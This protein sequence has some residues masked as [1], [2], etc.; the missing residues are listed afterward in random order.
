MTSRTVGSTAENRRIDSWKEIAA[1]FGRDERTVKRW[2]KE[3]GLP[4]HRLPG[5]RGGVFAWSSELTAW[6]N[7]SAAAVNSKSDERPLAAETPPAPLTPAVPPP[8]VPSPD[9]SASESAPAAPSPSVTATILWALALVA[10]VFAVSFFGLRFI[11][12]S[13]RAPR[14]A[15]RGTAPHHV[16]DPEAREFYLKG[17]YYWSRRTEGSLR[18]AVDA[19]T[20]AVIHDSEYA[21]A[22]AGL[23]ECYDIMPEFSSMPRSEAFP[24]AIAAAR[25][26]EALD[27][28]LAEAHRALAFALFYWEWKVP[29]AL[30]EYQRAL[31]LD[32]R[33]E[34][35]HH[36][37]ATSLLTLGRYQEAMVEIDKA[38]QLNPASRS[39]LSDQ[40]L[41]R[42]WNGDQPAAI[43]KLR[44]IEQAEPEFF[45]AP[46]YLAGIAFAQ[47]D[48][49][50]FIDQSKRLAGM[51]G[52][53]QLLAVTK[54]AQRGFTTG[55]EHGLLEAIRE[56]QQGYFDSGQASGLELARTCALLGRKQ[57]AVTYLKAAIA[58]HDYMVLNISA[59]PTFALL[60]GDP[61]F[62]QVLRQITARMYRA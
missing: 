58:N 8:E 59:E 17:R 50:T 60:N 23:A 42:F 16:P 13:P 62:E 54:A 7:S 53:E 40:A 2:E 6:L 33:D 29:A 28:S 5:E 41:I 32:P 52:D 39:I 56:V 51:S 27:D 18:Q 22:Y 25:K 11:R 36:W 12:H 31:Q 26:A 1:F 19:F 48:Y 37:Y 44:E 30:S 43:Q 9:P 35:A 57:E 14:D 24:R 10:A 38:Q 45:S 20:Q 21:Q 3:R 47:K 46:R 61:A 55:G 49:R 15:A 34:E 4:V